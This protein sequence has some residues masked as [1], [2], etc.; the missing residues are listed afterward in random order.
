MVSVMTMKA[1]MLLTEGRCS[2][3]ARL[4]LWAGLGWAG[5]EV[6]WHGLRRGGLSKVALGWARMGLTSLR[7]WSALA[8]LGWAGVGLADFA[9]L[10]C[11]GL[12]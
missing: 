9:L 2:L 10:V 12:G 1:V 4:Q 7:C 11:A 8:G 5:L 6:H 3:C